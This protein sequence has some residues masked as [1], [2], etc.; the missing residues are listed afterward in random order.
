MKALHIE[1]RYIRLL[2]K[3]HICYYLKLTPVTQFDDNP[4][5]KY[6]YLCWELYRCPSCFSYQVVEQSICGKELTQCA[7]SSFLVCNYSICSPADSNSC[8]FIQPISQF[9]YRLQYHVFQTFENLIQFV[10]Y[11][12]SISQFSPSFTVT[13]IFGTA[14]ETII[15]GKINIY[16][17]QS[18]LFRT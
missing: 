17:Q 18:S 4:T 5:S 11:V 3:F 2:H 14:L 16:F 12:K 6:C 9:H 7:L 13:S 15:I 1:A 8:I 10:H